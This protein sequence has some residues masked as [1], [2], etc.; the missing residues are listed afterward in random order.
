[1]FPDLPVRRTPRDI[2]E[3]L[4]ELLLPAIGRVGIQP[5]RRASTDVCRQGSAIRSP[6]LQPSHVDLERHLRPHFRSWPANV[7]NEPNG[8]ILYHSRRRAR[9]YGFP[10]DDG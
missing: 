10:L 4:F 7:G 8:R 3:R 2:R 6:R 1:M 9:I 5:Q